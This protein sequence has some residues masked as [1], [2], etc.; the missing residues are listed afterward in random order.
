M[1]K[2]ISWLGV[3]PGKVWLYL[4]IGG[5]VLITVLKFMGKITTA[6]AKELNLSALITDAVNKFKL[7]QN[8]EKIK[9]LD[10]PVKPETDPKKVEE[11]YK[12]RK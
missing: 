6:N 7:E 8:K 4:V 10:K 12:N 1:K 3:I 5:V 9:E 11:F 2:V